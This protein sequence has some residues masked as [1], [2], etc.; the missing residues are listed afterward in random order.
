MI[1]P[2]VPTD[3]RYNSGDPY[4]AADQY[5]SSGL[6]SGRYGDQYGTGSYSDYSTNRGRYRT[7]V[8]IGRYDPDGSGSG[9]GTSTRSSS[10]YGYTPGD[11]AYSYSAGATGF[12]YV[13]GVL[14]GDI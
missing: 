3:D 12:E 10:G 4:A 1:I 2:A 13:V 8:E 9:Y 14:D 7:S 6:T 5:G 11:T